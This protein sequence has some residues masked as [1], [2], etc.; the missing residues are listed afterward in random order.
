M[1]I[2]F[3]KTFMLTLIPFLALDALWLGT[4]APTFYKKHIGSILA[5]SP[6]WIAAVIFYLIFVAGL[7]VFVTYQEKSLMQAALKVAMF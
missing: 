3:L 5:P 7:V 1:P 2:A 4:M 6:N